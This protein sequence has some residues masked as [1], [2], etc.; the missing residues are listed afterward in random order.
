MSE[1]PTAVTSGDASKM[2]I[3]AMTD[4]RWKATRD[5][6]VRSSLLK[7][8]TDWKS[9][10]SLDFV[11]NLHDREALERYPG[12]LLP[13]S[14][15]PL[16]VEARQRLDDGL[17]EAILASG[18]TDL[19]WSWLANPSGED[20]VEACRALIS[21]L[22]TEDHRRPAAISRLRRLLSP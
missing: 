7:D 20:D 2:S 12:P 6:L 14:E 18:S 10:Y 17:R 15:V 13:T 19:L 22:G 3:G 9:A 8:S 16:V 21:R 1:L 5:F 11:K 4:V